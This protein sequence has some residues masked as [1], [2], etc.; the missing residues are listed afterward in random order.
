LVITFGTEM[1][2]VLTAESIIF[3][4]ILLYFQVIIVIVK[5]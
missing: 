3:C 2:I 4:D 5:P 1:T